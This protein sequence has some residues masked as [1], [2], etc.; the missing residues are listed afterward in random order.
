MVAQTPTLHTISEVYTHIAHTES[1]TPHTAPHTTTHYHIYN[2]N[3]THTGGVA[4][5]VMA[6]LAWPGGMHLSKQHCTSTMTGMYMYV[7]YMYVG[8]V[9]VC[10]SV[11]GG[12][13]GRRKRG[14]GR[15]T[16]LVRDDIP[17][18]SSSSGGGGVMTTN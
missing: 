15:D 6:W 13:G 5:N 11:W 16:L 3:T 1:I 2:T 9:C 8:Y 12:G 4:K 7:G 10:V 18:S 17:A 14:G